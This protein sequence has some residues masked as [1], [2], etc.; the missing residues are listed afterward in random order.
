M[1]ELSHVIE[2]KFYQTSKCLKTHGWWNGE[3]L[4][5]KEPDVKVLY[6]KANKEAKERV[7]C[8]DMSHP[9]L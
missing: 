4:K 8:L 2:V 5:H 3:A 6:S 9:Q 7:D 1:Q